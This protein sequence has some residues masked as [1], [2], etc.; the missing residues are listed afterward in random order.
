[1]DNKKNLELIL[2]Y[3]NRI[4]EYINSIE[5]K[6]FVSNQMLID[7]VVLNLEQIGEKANKLDINFRKQNSLIDWD[8]IIGLRHKAV[9]HYEGIEP[10]IIWD[11]A[12]DDIKELKDN[13]STL[14]KK[15]K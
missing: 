14:I 8:D 10:S 9:H 15:Y 7:A 4:E 12:K 5:Y 1:M 3:I 6:D 2:V 13:I 11:I